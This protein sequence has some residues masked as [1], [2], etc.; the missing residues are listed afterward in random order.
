MKTI[1]FGLV[2]LALLGGCGIQTA[3]EDT[4]DLVKASN[5][6]QEDIL[7]GIEHTLEATNE[8]KSLTALQ[9][10]MAPENTVFLDPPVQMMTYAEIFVEKTSESNLTKALYVFLSTA[11]MQVPNPTPE[12]QRQQAVAFAAFRA[13]SGLMPDAKVQTILN[14]EIIRG[15]RYRDTAVMMVAARYVFIRDVLLIALLDKSQKL[16]VGSLQEAAKR[17]KSLKALADL[18]FAPKAPLEVPAVY[19]DKLGVDGIDKL[20]LLGEKA[21]DAF[22]ED[23][24]A[25]VYAANKPLLDVFVVE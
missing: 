3:T 1:L 15:G 12:Q 18:P 4:R 22:K 5:S 16:T 6:I 13:V 24:S 19:K 23:L 21:L 10:M 11:M 14:N 25:E 9:N 2:S 7:R 20:K 8:L 17:F